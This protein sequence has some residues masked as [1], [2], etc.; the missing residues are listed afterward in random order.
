MSRI[1]F[2]WDVESQQMERFDSEDIQ[3]KRQRRRN[4]ILLAVLIG[5]LLASIA[6]ILFFV[7]H[8]VHEVETQ[9]AQLLQD[10]VKAEVAALRIGDLNSFL[11]VQDSEDADWI[12]RQRLMFQ[13]YSELKSSGAIELTASILAVDIA[14]E[15][16][17]ALVQEDINEL[18]YVRLWFYR[19]SGQG[20]RH[21]APDFSFWGEPGSIESPDVVV[22]YRDADH[23]LARQV[24]AALQE[25]VAK[26]CEILD[27][28]DLPKLTAVIDPEAAGEVAWTNEPAMRLLIRSPY[29]D[30][31]RADTPFDG[32][33]RMLVSRMIA[34]RLV[35]AHTSSL[36]TES[37]HDADFLRGAAIAW[38]SEV[39]TRLDSGAVLMRSLADNYGDEKVARLL[40]QLSATSDM[41]ILEAALDQPLDDADLDWRDFIE[42]RLAL[43]REL[44]IARR[45]NEWLSLYDT[46]DESARLAAYERYNRGETGPELRVIDQ[47]IWSRPDGRSQLRVTVQARGDNG[48]PVEIVL[49]NLVNGA[50]KRAS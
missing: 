10:T 22:N 20:W 28:G 40:T 2:E 24:S 26:G 49:F 13:R 1:R 35:D 36:A 3:A 9:F 39:F 46:A 4:I 27:C 31:A 43:E 7:R 41:S 48:A 37:P 44:L 12:N 5:L 50:W 6:L 17:R 14:G 8:R 33:L 45:Q 38:L 15:S 30:I 23:A 25:W 19:R 34:E 11:N 16:A 18:P 32:S 47:L 21:I 29:V 42:W